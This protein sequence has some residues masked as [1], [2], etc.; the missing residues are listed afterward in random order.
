MSQSVA[1]GLLR[2][3]LTAVGPMIALL[4]PMDHGTIEVISGAILTIVGAGWS[5][6]DKL[7]APAA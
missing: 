2:H 7:K 1:L 5:V 3:L 4:T 6:Y